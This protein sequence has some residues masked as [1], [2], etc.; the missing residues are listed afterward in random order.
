MRTLERP[1][2][3]EWQIADA[4]A[5]IDKAIEIY[6]TL[7]Y[8]AYKTYEKS[9]HAYGNKIINFFRM[10]HTNKHERFRKICNDLIAEKQEKETVKTISIMAN[11]K[12]AFWQER[13]MSKH[14]IAGMS[15][16]R[17][18]NFELSTWNDVVIIGIPY[19]KDTP[20]VYET[21]VRFGKTMAISKT[22]TPR[23][24][25]EV[26]EIYKKYDIDEIS[27]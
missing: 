5:F 7:W 10:P 22:E 9:I 21:V 3:T 25:K 20:W 15:Y 2:L 19:R 24:Y 11:N 1:K 4:T 6:E 8:E 18:R 14:E 23:L 12:H 26:M 13:N 27:F 17:L 16:K